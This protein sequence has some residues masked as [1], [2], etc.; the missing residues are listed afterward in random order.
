M[1]LVKIERYVL[2]DGEPPALRVFGWVKLLKTWASLR[3]SDLQAIK[4]AELRLTDGRLATTLRKTK[5][6]GR[7]KRI[8]EL[9][10]CVSEQAFFEDPRWLETGFDLLKGLASFKRDYLLP[11][12]RDG[13][14]GFDKKMAGYGDAMV[15][16]S[17]LLARL[18]IPGAVQ[19][20]WTARSERSVLPTALSI[21]GVQAREGLARALEAGG[22]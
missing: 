22:L 21:I 3:W 18:H 15:A 10:V 20:L 8:K 4:P 17:A 16:T 5:T 7:A 19:G 14:A 13:L 1:L 6:S 2:D 11:R 12:L 9:P